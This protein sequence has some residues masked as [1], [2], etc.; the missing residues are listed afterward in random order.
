MGAPVS[1]T[2]F[3]FPFAETHAIYL[4]VAANTTV[5]TSHQ[6]ALPAHVSA[7]LTPARGLEEGEEHVM[8]VSVDILQ[9]A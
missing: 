2:Q 5:R 7:A 9:R 8:D 3:C 4:R 1:H 6:D